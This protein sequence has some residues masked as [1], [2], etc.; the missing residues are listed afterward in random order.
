M[1]AVRKIGSSFWFHS[2][3]LLITVGGSLCYSIRVN[4]W[5]WFARSGSLMVIGGT[6]MT[7]RFVVL[8]GLKSLLNI[9]TNIDLN[10]P[11]SPEEQKEYREQ[12]RDKIAVGVGTLLMLAGTLVWAY[13]DLI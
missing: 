12:R 1:K 9:D 5:H 2:I 13:G 11:N 6:L 3:Y 7:F 4:D 10:W 8:R